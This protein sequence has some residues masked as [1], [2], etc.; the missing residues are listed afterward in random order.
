MLKVAIN[1]F[2]RIGRMF[3]RIAS[4]CPDLEI[5]AINASYESKTLAHLLKYDSVHGRY[6]GEVE[7]GPDYLMVDGRKIR[8]VSDRDPANLPWAAL[9]VDLVIEATG[10]FRD[11][12]GAGR[13]LEAGARKVLITAPAKGEDLTVVMGVNDHLYDPAR[14]HIVSGASC[15]TNALA[16]VAKVLND[17]F[18]IISGLMTTIHAYTNDQHIVDN[19]HQD[20]R[21][22]RSA[23][24]SI[25]PTTTGAAKAV[26]LVLPELAGK[27]NGFSL[28]VPT[29]DVS[30]VDL[31]VRLAQD[32]TATAVNLAL[33]SAAQGGMTGILG[34]T[35]EPLVSSDYIGD[36]RSAIVDGLSTLMGPDGM[37]KVI[38]WYDNEWGYAA[39]I[40]DLAAH[41]SQSEQNAKTLVA[42]AD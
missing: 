1:G 41:I 17:R 36:S 8:L 26:S 34:Y 16:P 28:R 30:V 21:R 12:E 11:R 38:A 24:L 14:H 31:T 42:S 27:L 25:I 39:R 4:H 37:V 3:C 2:G 20:L 9:G 13:H 29:P 5:V 7:A 18:G 6:A 15:T 35:D 23:A 10:K 33:Q 40:V 22:A 19:P 32:V